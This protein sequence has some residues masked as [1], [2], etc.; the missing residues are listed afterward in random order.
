MQYIAN[1][2]KRYPP[3]LQKIPLLDYIRWYSFLFFRAY[4]QKHTFKS[5]LLKKW[6]CLNFEESFLINFKQRLHLLQK[7]EHV[8]YFSNISAI[9]MDLSMDLLNMYFSNISVVSMDLSM[10]LI[11]MYFSNISTIPMDLTSS[12]CITDSY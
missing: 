8:K 6:S 10:D 1:T 4:S 5:F 7:K 11:D 3:S 9:S 2:Q 12:T